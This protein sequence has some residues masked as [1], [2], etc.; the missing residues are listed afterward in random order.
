MRALVLMLLASCVVVH[1]SA[2]PR[3]PVYECAAEDGSGR[4]ESGDSADPGSRLC[5][6]RLQRE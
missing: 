2:P 6:R 3:A 5:S 4:A 1:V